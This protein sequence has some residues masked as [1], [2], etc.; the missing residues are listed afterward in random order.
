MDPIPYLE[1]VKIQS[2]ILLPLYKR[3]REEIGE[4]RAR[5]LLKEAVEEYGRSMGANVANTTQGAP[6]DKLRTLMPVFAAGDALD[7]EPLANDDKELSLNVRGCKYA[8]YFAEI[9]E[10]EF[11]SMITCDV[12]PP[13]TAGIG[14]GLRLERTQTILK[15]GSHCDF[16]WKADG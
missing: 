11:G 2:E 5:V 6:L 16:R 12:D 13:L 3:L 14:E 9:G 4:E 1:R 7:I 10:P 15:G 8:E